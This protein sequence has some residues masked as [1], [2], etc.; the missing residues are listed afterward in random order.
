MLKIP[1]G[2]VDGITSK[3]RRIQNG[4]QNLQNKIKATGNNK[5]VDKVT[6][7][8][9]NLND[10]INKTPIDDLKVKLS[11][12]RDSISNAFST[13]PL[14]NFKSKIQSLAHSL[15]SLYIVFK[16]QQAF[17]S[18]LD[19]ISVLKAR[20]ELIEPDQ[21]KI[22][23]LED[24]L[25]NKSIQLGIKS[26]D[27][28]ENVINMKQLTGDTFANTNQ[29][30]R[31]TELMQKMFRISGTSTE[32]ARSGIYQLT[33]AMAS[34]KLQGDEY[35]SILENIPMLGRAIATS[36][37]VSFGEL[38][39]LAAKGKITSDQIKKAVF[40][41]GDEIDAKFSKLPQT[42]GQFF[43]VIYNKLLIIA[44]G[45]I[46]IFNKITSNTALMNF[47]DS[48][49]QIL[50]AGL[51]YLGV[52][53]DGVVSIISYILPIFTSILNT[54]NTFKEAIMAVVGAFLI[55]KSVVGAAALGTYLLQIAQSAYAVGTTIVSFIVGVLTGSFSLL[56]IVMGIAT[57]IF[58][59][60]TGIITFG[61]LAVIGIIYLL[62]KAYNYLFNKGASFLG[63][64]FGVAYWIFGAIYNVI[65]GI[66]NG[67]IGMINGLI[68]AGTIIAEVIFNIFKNPLQA[69]KNFVLDILANILG[70]FGSFA[71]VI[72]AVF[73]TGMST[74]LDNMSSKLRGMKKY[75]DGMFKAGDYTFSTVGTMDLTNSF[76]KGYKAGENV[77]NKID[78]GI[79]K[80]TSYINGGKSEDNDKYDYQ[81]ATNKQLEDINNNTKGTKENTKMFKE[82]LKLL[83]D[84]AF[85]EYLVQNSANVT[86]KIENGAVNEN[87]NL[88]N[89]ANIADK[90]KEIMIEVLNSRIGTVN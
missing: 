23:A 45:V 40:S 56:N 86:V 60:W 70:Y 65:A 82:D 12:L 83:R 46:D 90:F 54:I 33:Q 14:S 84:M 1:L 13:N 5:A 25:Y 16:S 35:R 34:G 11:T 85:R 2:V 21:S 37:G 31:F 78:N 64:L 87:G 53:F 55:Y 29:V 52:L 81:D 20:L 32:A 42:W 79:S 62:V 61:I 75:T 22:R 43:N 9:N 15:G 71:S 27:F 7:S 50:G 17:F 57:T 58:A 48:V 74:K 6:D 80:V 28:S 39:G 69:A 76:D 51:V 18:T 72:D 68:R 8:V 66:I 73:G 10:T 24:K 38:K 49:V 59:T 89:E 88:V 44:E 63:A 47:I 77:Q 36:M 67:F 26:T 30:V 41:M 4:F 19:K 3:L